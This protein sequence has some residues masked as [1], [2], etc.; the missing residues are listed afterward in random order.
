ML[1]WGQVVT[2]PHVNKLEN[3]EDVNIEVNNLTRKLSLQEEF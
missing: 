2:V 3:T 1:F